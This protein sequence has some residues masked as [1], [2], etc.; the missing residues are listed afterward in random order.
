[1]RTRTEGSSYQSGYDRG[2]ADAQS[3]A[4]EAVLRYTTALREVHDQLSRRPTDI[5]VERLRMQI[6][7]ALR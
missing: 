6:E 3:L 7:E 5:G 4:A 2:F 1:M